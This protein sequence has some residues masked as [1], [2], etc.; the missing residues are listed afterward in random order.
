M[1]RV[2]A[3]IILG[4]IG[5]VTLLTGLL[6]GFSSQAVAY[7]HTPQSQVA[8]FLSADGVGYLQLATSS[9][10]YIVHEDDFRPGIN[11]S[12]FG[13]GDVISLVYDPSATTSID[14]SSKLGTHLVGDA[15]KVVEITL[16]T[17]SGITQFLTPDYTQHQDGYSINRWPV[18]GGIAVLGLLIMCL[19]I[20]MYSG[21][22]KHTHDDG[23]VNPSQGNSSAQIITQ[24]VQPLQEGQARPPD[25]TS[26]RQ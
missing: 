10:L 19:A 20:Y 26:V 8:H 21:R 1:D 23:A 6:Y 11:E 24:D 12:S 5:L 25:N 14:V 9:S 17:S 4:C 15:S 2:S 7:Q 16:L 22:K 18:G 3:S 13:D